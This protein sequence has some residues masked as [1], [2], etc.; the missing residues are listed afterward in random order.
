[1]SYERPEDYHNLPFEPTNPYRHTL[2]CRAKAC[3]HNDG[4]EPICKQDLG[5]E[6]EENG[7]CIHYIRRC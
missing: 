1:M 3:V 7:F 5:L 4:K 2:I 6:I